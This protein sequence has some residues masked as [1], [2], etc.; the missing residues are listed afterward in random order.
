DRDGSSSGR[1]L[2]EDHKDG[3]HADTAVSDVRRRKTDWH[4]EILTFALFGDDRTVGNRVWRKTADLHIAFVADLPA[5]IDV[6]LHVVRI[7]GVGGESYGVF[8]DGSPL[9]VVLRHYVVTDHAASLADVQLMWPAGEISEL[10]FAGAPAADF[11]ADLCRDTGIANQRPNQS[12][13]ILQ[14]LTKDFVAS[15]VV[16]VRP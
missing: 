12:L 10:V 7:H 8:D 9:A 11:V 15:G 3:L 2:P 5:T 1:R 16:G 4:E 14:V 6:A 13:L